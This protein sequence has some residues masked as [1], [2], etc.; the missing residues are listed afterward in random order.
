[1]RS[2]SASRCRAVAKIWWNI[3]LVNRPVKVFCW[4]GW[5]EPISVVLQ[6]RTRTT[7][8]ENFGSGEEVAALI[9]AGFQV[10]IERNLAQRHNHP[11]LP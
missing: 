2:G 7:P 5:Y 1:V 8:W 9:A 3:G 10:V 11:D 6:G 4:L